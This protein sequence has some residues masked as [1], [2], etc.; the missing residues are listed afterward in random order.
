[1]YF[2]LFLLY[3]IVYIAQVSRLG[4]YLTDNKK[5]KQGDVC[6][7]HKHVASFKY[8]THEYLFIHYNYQSVWFSN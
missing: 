6:N 3:L 2:F 7:E 8:F 4:F 5:L 1:M